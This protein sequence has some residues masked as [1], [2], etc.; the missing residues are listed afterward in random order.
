MRVEIRDA[1]L[2]DAG[3]IS[4]L[5]RSR[6]SVWQRLDA[7]GYVEDVTY[8]ALTL[9]ERW[10]HGGAWMAVETGAVALNHFLLGGGVALVGVVDGQAMAYLEAYPGHEQEPFGA[11]LHVANLVVHADAMGT[12]VEEFLLAQLTERAKTLKVTQLT[13][14]HL[15]QNPEYAAL[16][17]FVDMKTLIAQRRFTLSA[18]TGQVFYRAVD[19]PNADPAQIAGMTMPVG[20]YGSARQMW[21]TVWPRTWNTIPE[22]RARKTHR[23]RFSGA[24]QDA[25]IC[26][27]QQLYDPRGAD[28]YCWA[29]KSLSPQLVTSV[30][31]W[32]HRE[33]YRTLS[34]LVPEALAATL[35]PE[36]EADGFV[37]EICAIALSD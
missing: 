2:E 19:H 4:E 27:Q 35:G 5:F 26:C 18:R 34:M 37:Q 9:Y 23:L 12:G 25:F 32:A 14:T 21:E 15:G 20:R 33:G 31:D 1:R 8:D 3:A 22:I 7:E 13:V 36:A 24:G 17:P 6:I 10:L 11:H 30:R 16:H 28:V 29:T